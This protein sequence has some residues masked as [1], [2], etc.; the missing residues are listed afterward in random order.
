M[1]DF[2]VGDKVRVVPLTDYMHPDYDFDI[3][4]S[5]QRNPDTTIWTITEIEEDHGALLTAWRITERFVLFDR[6]RHVSAVELL[7]DVASTAFTEKDIGRSVVYTP[8]EGARTEDGV[9]TG[10]NDEY[11]FVRYTGDKGSKATNP[12]DLRWLAP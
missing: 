10:V 1:S 8:Y 5:L 6:L 12:K 9:I 7:A 3:D 4:G 11:V 2:K